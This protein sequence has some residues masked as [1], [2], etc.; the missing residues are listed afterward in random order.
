M[1]VYDAITNVFLGGRG[2]QDA[3]SR[4]EILL[5]DRGAGDWQSKI[6]HIWPWRR[7]LLRRGSAGTL[8][9]GQFDFGG[10]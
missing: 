4:M 10:S 9:C 5:G 2:M 6:S 7:W 8:R 1:T 3:F